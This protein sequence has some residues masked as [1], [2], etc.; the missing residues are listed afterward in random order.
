MYH[1]FDLFTMECPNCKR[2]ISREES[3]ISKV[4]FYLGRSED[5]QILECPHCA[6]LIVLNLKVTHTRPHN[7]MEIVKHKHVKTDDKLSELR[8]SIGGLIKDA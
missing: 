5:T 3:D 1:T 6:E 8:G 4:P 2:L 7:F